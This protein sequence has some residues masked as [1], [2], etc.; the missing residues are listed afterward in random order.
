MSCPPQIQSKELSVHD[1]LLNAAEQVVARNGV[2]NLTLDAVAREAGVSKGGLLYHFP[3][4]SALITAIVERLAR[5]CDAEH[6][7]ALEKEP[8]APGAFTRAYLNARMRPRDPHEE[9]IQ[10]ALLAAAGTDSH[11]LD[12]FRKR[13][14]EWQLRLQDDGIDPV[15]AMIIRLAIDGLCMGELLDIPVPTGELRRQVIDRLLAMTDQP[16]RNVSRCQKK[17]RTIQ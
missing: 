8:P 3:S 2:S 16:Q 14:S 5:R 1:R 6:A 4:K 11:Y 10:T 13:L 15:A 9:L 12:A 17:T 7:L